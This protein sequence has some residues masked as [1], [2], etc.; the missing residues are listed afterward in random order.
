MSEAGRKRLGRRPALYMYPYVSPSISHF[1]QSLAKI[2]SALSFPEHISWRPPG[3]REKNHQPSSIYL[4][5]EVMY[6]SAFQLIQ[7]SHTI[8]YP[9]SQEIKAVMGR[10][11]EDQEQMEGGKT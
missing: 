8:C 5:I 7:L 10:I 3:Q 6:N 11:T 9:V 1:R 4:L 2:S